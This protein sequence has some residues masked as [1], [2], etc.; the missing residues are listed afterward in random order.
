MESKSA[1]FSLFS[2]FP[3]IPL[4]DNTSVYNLRAISKEFKGR[5]K[6]FKSGMNQSDNL[7]FLPMFFTVIIQNTWT[8]ILFQII[9]S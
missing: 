1:F 7:R 5:M 3:A 9:K 2:A 6:N 8:Y 4:G